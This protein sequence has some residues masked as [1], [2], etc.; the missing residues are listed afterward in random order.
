M[1]DARLHRCARHV[2]LSGQA[3]AK[4]HLCFTSVH[5]YLANI[6]TSMENSAGSSIIPYLSQ[7]A[8][9]ITHVMLQAYHEMAD[10]L[11]SQGT[12]L[13]SKH[14]IREPPADL[15][16]KFC[17]PIKKL[18]GLVQGAAL[19]LYMVL[20]D[21]GLSHHHQHYCACPLQLLPACSAALTDLKRCCYQTHLL[22]H[23]THS[24]FPCQTLSTWDRH[25]KES[26]YCL[27]AF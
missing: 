3:H 6:L 5:V 23:C 21:Y 2:H 9:S 8:L 14:I 24:Y 15:E 12:T 7:Y 16:E 1:K 18:K 13:T 27:S 19:T 22:R 4:H 10:F 20:G 26:A 25:Q 11:I 17:R